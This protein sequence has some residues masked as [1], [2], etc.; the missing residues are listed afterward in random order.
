MEKFLGDGS[1][2]G[3]K[4]SFSKE[5]KLLGTGGGLKKA[6]PFFA[7]E[8]LVLVNCDFISNAEL[9]PSID[10]HL[11]RGAVGTMILH[12]N[13]DMQPFYSKVG[14]DADSRLCRLP[15]CETRP[16]AKSGIFT[17]I[18]LLSP[19]CFRY[20]KETPSGINEVLY[21]TLMKESP[22]LVRGVFD[23][24]AYWYDTG[25]RATLW[26]ASMRLL[27]RLQK[28]DPTLRE[29]LT[30]FGEYDEAA[31]GV[32]V[33][34]GETPPAHAK[35]VPPLVLGRKCTI[36]DNVT[37]GPSCLIGEGAIVG[38]GAH[39]KGVV[40]LGAAQ[41]PGDRVSEDALQFHELT[42]SAKR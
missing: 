25:E 7:G 12:Q 30:T 24:D 41:I 38:G 4:L 3:M 42:L 32:W 31:P 8:P 37:L 17:G 34:R 22:D 39:V 20:L 6:E 28:G 5:T 33:A 14:V 1:R 19:D 13:P 10:E 40:A 15:S 29:F 27:E 26:N 16:P 9:G 36:G 21:P 23:G 35:L 11:A 2:W 18:H